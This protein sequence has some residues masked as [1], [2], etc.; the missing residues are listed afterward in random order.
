[1]D[2]S[3]LTQGERGRQLFKVVTGIP[4]ELKGELPEAKTVKIDFF[5]ALV[6]PFCGSPN[7]ALEFIDNFG[8]RY[9]KC[10]GCGKYSKV[11]K[12]E[13]FSTRGQNLE[14]NLFEFLKEYADLIKSDVNEKFLADFDRK[15]ACDDT[16][17]RVVFLTGLSAYSSEPMNL[18]LRGPPSCG[19]SFNTTQILQYFPQEDVWYL[20]GLSPT[21]LIHE[22]GTLVDEDGKPIDLNEKPRKSDFKGDQKGYQRALREWEE[23]LRN[24]HYEI[25]LSNKI[26]VFLEAP[27]VETYMMLRPL[28]SHDTPEI[29]YKFTDKTGRGQLRTSHVILKGWPATIFC[30]SDVKY[31]EDLATR[32]FTVTPEMTEKKYRKA[33]ELAAVLAAYPEKESEDR[34]YHHL[35]GFLYHIIERCKKGFNKV[36]IPYAEK[37]SEAYPAV[38]PRDM[39]DFKRFLNLIQVN[40]ILNL[41]NRPILEI[42]KGKRTKYYILADMHDLRE[43]LYIFENLEQTTR[44]GIPGHILDFFNE[45]VRPLCRERDLVTYRDLTDEYNRKHKDKRSTRTIRNWC[46]LLSNVGLLSVEPHPEDR[47]FKVVILTDGN[48]ENYGISIKEDFFT[49]K[50]LKEWFFK[51]KNN[52]ETDL[53]YIRK[54]FNEKPDIDFITINSDRV[55]AL[56]SEHFSPSI[57]KGNE[58]KEPK[59]EMPQ[60]SIIPSETNNTCWICHRLLPHGMKDTTYL[61]GRPVHLACYR[62]LMEG[63]KKVEEA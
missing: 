54:R 48:V 1:M 35:K 57:L 28:L 19:K 50:D 31:V 7:L 49:I 9:L 45:I 12:K 32:G 20:G 10:G 16:V 13:D 36:L 33:N 8:G 30:T 11:S 23:R 58:K 17:K 24:S 3:N 29:S 41:F 39:R 46:E 63:I 14:Q 44:L 53:V 26:L 15:I 59:K 27:H 18:F 43:A 2:V 61:E 6:C 34:E 42:H 51:V 47:R 55:S 56:F 5:D 40:A 52:A 4:N 21:A 25:E 37:L 38:L 62:K 22:R 60:N